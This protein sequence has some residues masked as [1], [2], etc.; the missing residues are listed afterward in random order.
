MNVSSR[1][2][3]AAARAAIFLVLSFG[4]CVQGPGPDALGL[5]EGQPSDAE[6]P[7]ASAAVAGACAEPAALPAADGADW[8]S[9]LPIEVSDCFALEV[10]GDPGAAEIA[11][12]GAFLFRTTAGLTAAETAA[13]LAADP[14][15]TLRVDEVEPGTFRVAPADD[16]E[17]ATLFKLTM[18][19]RPG[20]RPLASWGFQVA[21]PL[22]MVSSVPSDG[23]ADVPLDTGIE[24]TFSHDAVEGVAD[25]LAI[26]PEVEGTFEVHRRTVVFVPAEPLAAGTLYSVNV[27]AGVTAGGQATAEPIGFGFET[28]VKNPAEQRDGV[29]LTR[30]LWQ[31]PVDE[32]PAVT[33]YPSGGSVGADALSAR[34]GVHRLPD[35]DGFIASLHEVTDIPDW[36]WRTRDAASAETSA[37]PI[38]QIF[39]AELRAIGGNGI[40]LLEFPEPLDQGY[41]LADIEVGETTSQAWLQVT[42]VAAYAAVSE[43]ATLV[44]AH[45]LAGGKPLSDAEVSVASGARIG[46]TDADGVLV[47]AAPGLVTR[48]TYPWGARYE[49]GGEIVITSDSG[50]VVVPVGTGLTGESAKGFFEMGAPGPEAAYWRYL[51]TDRTL[52]RSSDTVH[53]WGVARPREGAVPEKLRAVI[54]GGEYMGY[55]GTPAEVGRAEVSVSDSGTYLGELAFEGAT[56]GFY[57]LEIIDGETVLG[58]TYIEIKDFRT[59]AY[60]M[61]VRV[62]PAVAFAYEPMT[63]TAE[64]TFFEGSPVPGVQVAFDPVP[65]GVSS[66][67]PEAQTGPDGRAVVMYPRAAAGQPVHGNYE[68]R[69]VSVR[70]PN[71]EAGDI[72]AYAQT[73]V[74]AAE[75]ALIVSDDEDPTDAAG[76]VISG[77]VQSVDLLDRDASRPP[78]DF[79]GDSVAGAPVEGKVVRITWEREQ[80][81]ETYDYITKKT[82][83]EY[84]YNE[85]RKQIDDFS[86]TTDASGHFNHKLQME[87]DASYEVTIRV[88]DESERE[89]SIDHW[90]F[91]GSRYQPTDRLVLVD[92]DPPEDLSD[93][94]ERTYSVGDNVKLRIERPGTEIDPEMPALF[95]QAVAGVRSAAVTGSHSY[96]FPFENDAIP[97]VNVVGVMFDGRTFQEAESPYVAAV[98]LEPMRLTVRVEAEEPS[99]EPGDEATLNVQVDDADGNGAQAEVLLSAVDAAVVQA[100]G[101]AGPSDIL[102]TLYEHI[103]TGVLSTY[104][105]HVPAD[106]QTG[107]EGGGG[108]DARSDFKDTALFTTVK[109]DDDGHAMVSMPLPDNLTSW[110]VAALAV[111]P[112]LRAGGGSGSVPVSLPAFLD[113]TSNETYLAA[114]EPDVRL[115]A[116]GTALSPGDP[117]QFALEAPTLR[118]DDATV[119]G[120]AFAAA[121]VPLD[122]LVAGM[123]TITASLEADSASESLADSVQ[124]S[125]RVVSSR[126]TTVKSNT[127]ELDENESL[128]VR[129][130]QES[131]QTLTLA[132]AGRGRYLAGLERLALSGGDR[133]DQATAR[134]EG[135]SLLATYFARDAIHDE[136]H[137]TVY[138]TSEGGVALFPYSDVDLDVSVWSALAAPE[139]F[140]RAGL[141]AY[142]SSVAD[143]P[144]E[145]RERQLTAM[146]GLA[147]LGQPVLTSLLFLAPH[148]AD[149]T[150]SE[151]LSAGLAY[152]ASGD[153]GR[154]GVIY[155][156][157]LSEHGNRLGD[158]ARLEVSSD[159]EEVRQATS[160]AAALGALLGDPY[161]PLLY[162]FSQEN[163]P[164]ET[165]TDLE[166]IAFLRAW[167][168]RTKAAAAQAEVTIDG[169]N[170]T[171]QLDAG[172]AASFT[173]FREAS[174]VAQQGRL[175]A[176]VTELAPVAANSGVADGPTVTRTLRVDVPKGDTDDDG[177][178]EVVE[179]DRVVVTLK[180]DLGD[181][182]VD[183]CYAVTDVAPSGLVPVTPMFDPG[184]YYEDPR[185]L[186]YAIDG[187]R[188]SYCAWDKSKDRTFWY[189]ARMLATGKYR[190]DPPTIQSQAAP[191]L[192]GFGKPSTVTIEP[193]VR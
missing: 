110:N 178:L 117:V 126:T 8:A 181:D 131:G 187:Q 37:L 93:G 24:L 42:N 111:S 139:T 183:G 74:F 33:L 144:D 179:G 52:Y 133:A 162:A 171:V 192:I 137:P 83:P 23:A 136:L 148:D 122:K 47:A 88:K 149:L 150:P 172:E 188:V 100:Q 77:T 94:T 163:P 142:L 17:P 118:G 65:G 173:G 67:A 16:L 166:S 116:F 164:T 14:A 184:A 140:G 11:T 90:V 53:F 3:S 155:A 1:V 81:G 186:P 98:D 60:G 31:I 138:Q 5:P 9:V 170:R 49:P 99:Y 96:E 58:T 104:T 29:V 109:T 36:A 106:A 6:G 82:V 19:Q 73:V 97:D 145:T 72:S 103:S 39:E 176:T 102:A 154:A 121:W 46:S 165:V 167:L 119:D 66:T 4:G 2:R 76:R 123:H 112:G 158:T 68:W 41:Y 38:A 64:A 61:S 71:A 113:L 87:E 70:P 56:A 168:P 153:A 182:P 174:V 135:L 43:P 25:H 35:R 44:W 21:A 125:V 84:Q 151:A 124:R 108:G 193:A 180:V 175:S 86:A 105:S 22:R 10:D 161:A 141:I 120:E 157:L 79:F 191:E 57:N 169:E 27:D 45:D 62:D 89:V 128:E 159:G 51:Y 143:D 160:R 147:A 78:E 101:G 190:A 54:H 185:P 30:R 114:D 156:G 32:S 55:M 26:S 7:A 146:A 20:G 40:L 129:N 15:T 80:V 75:V 152:A 189:T 107:A 34:V 13:L 130:A 127:T 59:P 115:R 12:D 18:Y 95:Y 50:E 91:S 134:H 63:V 85:V 177:N 92:A 48:R 28:T 132:D 69:S